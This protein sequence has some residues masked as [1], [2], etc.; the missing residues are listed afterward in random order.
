M[1]DPK[2][3]RPGQPRT[4]VAHRL[5][6]VADRLRQLNTRFGLRSQ[7]VFLVWTRWTGEERGEGDESV[8]ARV[9][10]LPTPRVSDMSAIALRPWS[11]GMFPEGMLRVD[12]IS[13]GAY[14]A[15]NLKGLTIPSEGARAPRP[16]GSTPVS[17]TLLEPRSSERVDFFWEIAEDD[18]GDGQLTHR[19][20][21]RLFGEP[22][23][24]EGSLYWTVALEAASDELTRAGESRIT[25]EDVEE[26]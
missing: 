2:P 21:F 18:R 1:P 19:R 3:L 5:T 24:R 20:R 14:T 9:E 8:L 16:P 26:V 17:G 7:R 11:A 6:R 15:E 12:Q 22:A 13:A 23:R 25:E 4:T 10:L